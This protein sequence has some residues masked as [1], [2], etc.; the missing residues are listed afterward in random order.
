MSTFACRLPLRA[1]YFS[2]QPEE[3]RPPQRERAKREQ[4]RAQRQFAV[5]DRPQDAAE[6]VVVG[7]E[8]RVQPQ[9][10]ERSAEA[11]GQPGDHERRARVADAGPGERVSQSHGKG[12]RHRRHDGEKQQAARIVALGPPQRRRR[13]EQE[14][15]QK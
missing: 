13:Q 5:V 15:D 14:R 2:S 7:V 12:N 8:L 1:H 9:V 4:A 6:E 3:Q 10:V 11:D